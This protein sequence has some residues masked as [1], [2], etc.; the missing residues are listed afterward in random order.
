MEKVIIFGATGTLGREVTSRAL[1]KG[2]TVTAFARDPGKLEIEN[3]DLLKIPG[4]VLDP[5]AVA[6][7]V[8]GQDAVLFVVGA[9]LKGGVR[10]EGT[11][12]VVDA[13][14]KKG[15][16]R[17]VCLSTLGAGDSWDTL[18]FYWKHIMFGLLLRQA[19]ADHQEQEQHVAESDLDWTIVRPS[20]FTDERPE[21]ELRHG[22][23]RGADGLKL[24]VSRPEVADFILEEMER[25]AWVGKRPGIS[26]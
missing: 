18:N 16:R 15:V 3:A 6:E 10:S 22:D 20:A 11:R 14:N 8:E 4:D 26:H 23:L 12:N 13:M 25:K 17:L 19:Y 24:K 9:G 5:A 2:Y 1:E 21:G 7:A